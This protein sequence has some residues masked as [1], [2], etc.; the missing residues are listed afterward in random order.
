MHMR[1]EGVI[2]EK[3]PPEEQARA[4]VRA[5][6][7]AEA[8][9]QP[10]SWSAWLLASGPFGFLNWQMLA[11]IGLVLIGALMRFWDLGSRALHHDESMHAYY[12]W[13]QVFRGGGYRYDPLLHGPFQFYAPAMAYWLFGVSDATAR[14]APAFF[15]VVMIASVGLLRRWLTSTGTVIAALLLCFSPSY[16]YF[17]RFLREDIYTAAWTLLLVAGMFLYIETRRPLWAYVAAGSL[18]L[19]FATKE[20]TFLTLAILLGFLDAAVVIELLR[21]GRPL[22]VLWPTIPLA[23]GG[24]LITAAFIPMSSLLLRYAPFMLFAGTAAAGSIGV[25]IA[26]VRAYNAETATLAGRDGRRREER[27]TPSPIT[28]ALAHLWRDRDTF[29]WAVFVFL[30]LFTLFFTSFGSNPRGLRDG[31]LRSWMYWLEQHGVQ[32]GNQPM[33]YYL[34]LLAGYEQLIVLFALIGAGYAL[35]RRRLLF[36][37]FCA[38][39]WIAALVLYSYAG[40][41]M[42]WLIL[43]ILLPA[44]LLAA[45]FLG[46]VIEGKFARHWKTAALGTAAALFLFMIH[47]AWPLTYQRGDVPVDLLVYTQTS[48]DVPEVMR[49]IDQIAF[50]TGQGK[51]MGITFD[52]GVSWPFYWYLRDY[53]NLH[54]VPV[55]TTPPTDPVVLIAADQDAQA[56]QFL[57]NYTGVRYKL[58]WWFPEELYRQMTWSTIVKTPFD[59]KLRADLWRWLIY[60]EP[61]LPPGS[62]DFMF[63][64]RN[65][66]A[67]GW[68]GQSASGAAAAPALP[69][70]TVTDEQRYAE[71]RVPAA[72]LTLFGSRGSGN[73]QFIEPRGLAVEPQGNVWVTDP[74]NHRVQK[75]DAEGRFLLA[76][77]R[78][79]GTGEGQFNEPLGVATD[80]NGNVYVAD[81]WNHRIQKFD[82]SGRFLAQWTGPGGMWG[83]RALVVSPQ[84][85]V[86]VVDTGNKRVLVFDTEGR[87]LR[88]FGT[89]G[90]G[91]GQ[92]NEPIGIALASNGEVIIADTN[93]LRMQVF[94][95]DGRF[96]RMWAISGWRPSART[97]PYT[98]VDSAGNVYVSDPSGHR[99]LKFTP[100][101]QIAAVT[102]AGGGAPGQ[103]NLPTGLAVSGDRLYV[104]DTGNHRVQVLALP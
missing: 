100:D 103:F 45:W 76:L 23:L 102:G 56:R 33:W 21:R 15:G 84:G 46:T 50:R 88:Q 1:R 67:A 10:G 58:R 70:T 64:I 62:Y 104:A 12:S 79:K 60:R 92:L 29:W 61:A 17:S 9:P 7:G 74:G 27:P 31:L 8:A 98:A 101:G 28:D 77:G 80:A 82:A 49:Q 37:L 71:K 36:P 59:P 57:T 20:S 86:F 5:P 32:R 87:F 89:G 35:V 63:Y 75:F 42:P 85:E 18:A 43:H 94:S 68:G 78:G 38:Y 44:L 83:P 6:A 90:S 55:L 3:A 13:A 65:D 14:V 25:L 69:R 53:K 2:R 19:A 97:E 81:T 34:L 41:K 73:G 24:G 95:Q 51:Q 99:I 26:A 54:F 96:V 30:V 22:Q 39:W 72:L 91:A 4:P 16:L 52:A 40:E 93:N 47:T 11:L 66:L 48:P